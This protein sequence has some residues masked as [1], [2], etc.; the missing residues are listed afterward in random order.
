MERIHQINHD[1][2]YDKKLTAHRR[3]PEKFAAPKRFTQ[4]D[5]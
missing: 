4:K 5:T 2:L 1:R 3:N